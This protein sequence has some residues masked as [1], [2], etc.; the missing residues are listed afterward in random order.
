MHGPT[1]NTYVSQAIDDSQVVNLL[2]GRVV[3]VGGLEAPIIA[4]EIEVLPSLLHVI[5]HLIAAL[6]HGNRLLVLDDLAELLCLPSVF[7]LRGRPLKRIGYVILGSISTGL[8]HLQG[9]VAEVFLVALLQVMDTNQERVVHDLQLLQ[10][11][12]IPVHLLNES[13]LLDRSKLQVQVP[14]QPV[15]IFQGGSGVLLQILLLEISSDGRSLQVERAMDIPVR[16]EQVVHHHEVDF[17]AV[18]D[19]HTVKTVKLRKQRVGI[20]PNMVVV[21]LE[22]PPEELVLG[23]VDGLDDVLIVSRKIEKA[24]T[25]AGRSQFGKNVLA[26]QRHQVVRRV[27]LERLPQM[28]EHPGRV[29]LELEVVFGGRRQLVASAVESELVLASRR[30]D[31]K[32]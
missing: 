4:I 13:L 24:S 5:W 21:I 27:D 3:L 28:A 8:E 9:L 32:A 30:Q 12:H 2:S 17:A 1:C 25:L 22:D 11:L 7:Q 23:M 18:G 31:D 10:E 14:P 15:E 16:R 29:V 6:V 20:L 26:S 19:F